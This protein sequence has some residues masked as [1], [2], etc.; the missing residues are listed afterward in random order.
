MLSRR[1]CIASLLPAF[2]PGGT[3]SARARRVWADG[4]A[5]HLGGPSRD[6]R[7]LSIVDAATGDLA[8]RE[9]ASGE[10]RRLTGG[11]PHPGEFA[12]FSAVSR[13]SKWIAYAWFNQ[14]KFYDL[15]VIGADGQAQRTLQHNE[16]RRFVQPCS[17]TPDGKQI[18]T[19]FFRNDNIS[20]IALVPA[21]DG[22]VKVLQSLDWVYPNKMDLSPDGKWV[23]YDDLLREG[24]GARGLFLLATDGSRKMPAMKRQVNDVFPLFTPDGSG[25]V[26]L[27]T[28]AG[29]TDLWLQAMS[30]GDPELIEKDLGRALPLGFTDGGDYYYAL[31][32]GEPQV[33]IAALDGAPSGEAAVAEGKGTPD[34][35]PEGKRLAFLTRAGNENFGQESVVIAIYD[36]ETRKAAVL[37]PKLASLDHLRWSPDGKRFLAGGSDRHGERGLYVIDAETAAVKPVAL[38]PA[39]TYRGFEGVWTRGGEA[40]CFI[41]PEEG[42]IRMGPLDGETRV[43]YR[44]RAKAK[45]HDLAISADGRRIAF[46]MQ[47]EGAEAVLVLPLEGGEPRQ[48]A[49]VRGGAING[50]EWG[51]DGRWLLASTP[52][53]P[54]ALWRI[55]LDGTGPRKLDWNLQQ[56][57]AVRLDGSGR[58]IAYVAGKTQTEIRV[59]E[60]LVHAA[61][62]QR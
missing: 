35:S 11:E 26:F 60:R 36:T 45:L 5:S 16:E 59:I 37:A 21:G 43:I 48:A 51:R 31:R 19:L 38:T 7:F 61:H 4:Q 24:E 9:I 46:A 44:A 41:Q 17:W 33:R 22:A 42:A 23:V 57:G 3:T 58:R 18:L 12:Y 40:V 30:G 52:G 32:S 2:L 54:P 55:A 20:Q 1:A 50:L 15:R 10:V 29:T 13:D 8:V 6:G 56:Q 47:S 27:S 49:N 34:W 62:H 28:R 53:D 14:Q 25:I 39:E